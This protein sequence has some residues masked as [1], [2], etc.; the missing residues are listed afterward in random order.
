M[1]F[2]FLRCSWFNIWKVWVS[3]SLLN[4]SVFLQHSSRNIYSK[5]QEIGDF[6]ISIPL[7]LVK[8]HRCDFQPISQLLWDF[9]A[10]KWN[11]EYFI[12]KK[13]EKSDFEKFKIYILG[14]SKKN[15]DYNEDY[16]W[17]LKTSFIEFPLEGA[18]LCLY[19]QFEGVH[20]IQWFIFKWLCIY[21]QIN[22]PSRNNQHSAF[23]S[24]LGSFV[25]FILILIK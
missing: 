17:N 4:Q 5:K 7:A 3:R 6:G 14:Q 25:N 22:E 15:T 12:P 10:I 16:S 8:F 18:L 2:F 13:P 23:G 21:C 11:L 9:P 20:S 24:S 1:E 19:Q